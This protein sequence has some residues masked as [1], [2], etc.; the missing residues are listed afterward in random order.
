MTYCLLCF[1]QLIQHQQY[2]ED[3]SKIEEDHIRLAEKVLLMMLQSGEITLQGGYFLD[4][5]I[6][7]KAI[8]DRLKQLIKP[9][10]SYK[11]IFKKKNYARLI[12]L[13][14][15][16]DEKMVLI[17][18]F[19]NQ[20]LR[21]MDSLNML[22]TMSKQLQTYSIELIKVISIHDSYKG[23]FFYNPVIQTKMMLAFQCFRPFKIH[24]NITPIEIPSESI[25]DQ[26]CTP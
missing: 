21:H 14:R 22:S 25:Y 4:F 15:N 10:S 13:N 24:D 16:Y 11:I 7:R 17:L 19:L 20:A 1:F 23:K 12:A 9:I 5:Q 6:K 18:L 26:N 8:Q 3:G 2:F